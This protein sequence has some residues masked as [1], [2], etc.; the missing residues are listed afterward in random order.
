MSIRES[1]VKRLALRLKR[2]AGAR[3]LGNISKAEM[4][5][6]RTQQIKQTWNFLESLRRIP[7]E[8][9]FAT[10]F[11]LGDWWMFQKSYHPNMCRLCDFY[12]D[13]SLFNG[14][15]LRGTFPHLTVVDE[16]T[17]EP[18]VHPYC[19]CSLSRIVESQI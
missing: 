3:R 4:E 1:T 16:D 8:L 12:G 19:G 7:E 13:V 5:S 18:N 10:Y 17:I 11:G 6:Q 9:R 15:D 14:K 2:L